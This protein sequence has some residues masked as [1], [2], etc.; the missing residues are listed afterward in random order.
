VGEEE[1]KVTAPSAWK[2]FWRT[3]RNTPLIFRDP[4]IV[5]PDDVSASFLW[6]TYTI[7]ITRAYQVSP[8]FVITVY[9]KY[10]EKNPTGSPEEPLF[11]FTGNNPKSPSN[12]QKLF[13]LA[14]DLRDRISCDGSIYYRDTEAVGKKQLPF[15]LWKMNGWPIET[16]I[17]LNIFQFCADNPVSKRKAVM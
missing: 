4:S 13:M 8:A 12:F 11:I 15:R 2:F 16:E 9:R 1:F 17:G 5:N 10:D 6:F 14:G 3:N 7:V